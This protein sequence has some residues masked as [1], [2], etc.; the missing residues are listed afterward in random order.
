[1]R[2]RVWGAAVLLTLCLAACGKG[3]DTTKEVAQMPGFAKVAGS[4]GPES[5]DGGVYVFSWN[6]ESAF[7]YYWNFK[8][9]ISVPLCNKANCMHAD[10]TCNAWFHDPDV[11]TLQRYGNKLYLWC[12]FRSFSLYSENLDGTGREKVCT[13][14]SDDK[15]PQWISSAVFAGKYCYL[16]VSFG[17]DRAGSDVKGLYQVDSKTGKAKLIRMNNEEPGWKEYRMEDVVYD[18]GMVYYMI[19][20]YRTGEARS[21]LYRYNE[22]S[23]EDTLLYDVNDII[24][25]F[26]AD[27]KLYY[28]KEYE[29]NAK[30][31]LFVVDLETGQERELSV[32]HVGGLTYDGKWM[33]ITKEKEDN[34]MICTVCD[35]DGNV[36]AQIEDGF[37]QDSTNTTAYSTTTDQIVFF[38]QSFKDDNTTVTRYHVIEKSDIGKDPIPYHEITIED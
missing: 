6:P 18:N 16:N 21:L 19:Q 26:V 32:P 28:T 34:G 5:A 11:A 10:E 17:Q 9:D 14:S 2:K 36:I 27:N 24:Y 12:G 29:E 35:L 7:L 13:F 15:I 37:E 20:Q 38:R 4:A 25:E 31:T 3:E 8:D 33:Y 30:E 1:M 23:G 22:E